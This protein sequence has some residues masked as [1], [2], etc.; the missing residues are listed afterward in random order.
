MIA[1]VLGSIIRSGCN[2]SFCSGRT[3]R[4]NSKRKL[5]Q[6]LIFIWLLAAMT[7][8]VSAAEKKLN[9]VCTLPDLAAVTD[10]VGGP[11]ITLS[12]L[13]G[14]SEDPHFVDPRPS[15]AKLLNKADLLIEGGVDLE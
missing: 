8:V 12:C 4:I 1:R 7:L 2:S 11:L 5:M 10:Q 14:P 9:I 13:A 15:F 3:A 6:K